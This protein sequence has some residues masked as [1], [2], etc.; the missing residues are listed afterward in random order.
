MQAMPAQ[1]VAPPPAAEVQYVYVQKPGLP[2]WL[3]TIG[4]FA[5]LC[6]AGYAFYSLVLNKNGRSSA[7]VA[8][9]SDHSFA[10]R[11]HAAR[12]SAG[13][14]RRCIRARGQ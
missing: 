12:G 14:I 1:V 9:S 13:E 4:V 11:R 6:A 3:V 8:D 7:A 10:D 2:A 5:G